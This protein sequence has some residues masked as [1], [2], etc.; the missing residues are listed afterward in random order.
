MS[1]S[2]NK[3]FRRNIA[4]GFTAA[5][6]AGF[7]S[8][9]LLGCSSEPP[10]SPAVADNI[11]RSLDSAGLNDVKVSQDRDK[12]VITLDGKTA[13]E[14]Q[15]AQ[16]E[17]IARSYAGTQVVANQILVAPPG[18][19]SQARSINSDLD[20]AIEK[21]LSAEL[22]AAKLDDVKYEVKKGVVTL[23]GEVH[24]QAA[25]TRVEA[26]AKGIQNVQQVVNNLQVTKQKATSSH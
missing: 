24:T 13:S 3:R 9:L 14:D 4:F 2:Q 8:L 26:L 15:K 6:V 23:N 10:K 16:A 1:Q 7:L 17:T 20:D 5:I 11:R 22:K 25:R 12:G 19:E 18:A 21:N